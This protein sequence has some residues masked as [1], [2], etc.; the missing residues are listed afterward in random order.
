[1]KAVSALIRSQAA[2]HTHGRLYCASDLIAL[3]C[4]SAARAHTR[5]DLFALRVFPSNLLAYM[6]T[7]SITGS[8][9]ILLFCRSVWQDFSQATSR[10]SGRAASTRRYAQPGS[11]SVP[12]SD[13]GLSGRGQARS[14]RE[15][16]GRSAPRLRVMTTAMNDFRSAPTPESGV[17][18]RHRRSARRGAQSRTNAGG[19]FTITVSDSAR[20]TPRRASGAQPWPTCCNLGPRQGRQYSTHFLLHRSRGGPVRICQPQS[21]PQLCDRL[22]GAVWKS[23]PPRMLCVCAR[24]GG[25]CSL[26]D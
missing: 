2:H 23:T 17:G 11:C 22:V 16:M 12:R 21:V 26:V 9:T 20:S 15:V 6:K 1:M 14:S 19:R 24:G 10:L 3:G 5:F 25:S 7:G 4:A 18:A 13:C 8:R